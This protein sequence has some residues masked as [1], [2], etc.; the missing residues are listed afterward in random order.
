[1]NKRYRP[2]PDPQSPW[3]P[4]KDETD[5]PAIGLGGVNAAAV[6]HAADAFLSGSYER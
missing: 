2:L 1:M 5:G 3:Y 4:G 6:K